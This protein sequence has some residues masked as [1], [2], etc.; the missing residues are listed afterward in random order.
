[1]THASS[2]GVN[3]EDLQTVQTS[4]DALEQEVQQ[5]KTALRE[6]EAWLAAQKEAFQA[7]LNGA[8]LE[9]P[10]QVLV[11]AALDQVDHGTRCA[12]Y[13][14]D[15]Q[16]AELHHVTGMPDAYSECVDG[17]K[18][19]ANSLACGLAVYTGQ[20]VITAD[21]TKEPLWSSWLW[22]AERYDYRGCWSFPI[23]TMTGKVVGT[24]AMYFRGPRA[25]TPRDYARAAIVT[26]TA[27]IIISHS[28]EAKERDEAVEALRA[29]EAALR[30]AVAE[31]EALLKELH[32]RVKNNL[33]VIT[34]LLEIQA[35]QS[36]HPQAVASLAEA[37]NRIGAIASMHELLYR[38]ESL[39]A[40]DL[41]GYARRLVMHVVS[42]YR[43]DR[44]V[45]VSVLGNDIEVDLARAVP[46]GLLLNE[47]V[48]NACKH[49]FPD[50][51]AGDLEITLSRLQQGIRVRVRDTGV[52]LPQGLAPR[53]VSGLGLQLVHMLAKQV[54]GDVTFQSSGGTTVDVYVPYGPVND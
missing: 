51:G 18:V 1:M 7:A 24:F 38:S 30:R 28:R 49:A 32:H 9:V 22:L 26:R 42:F 6:N 36:G 34:S 50:D 14:T 20:P 15:P 54:G 16:G 40:V 2:R 17:F 23:E 43:K 25:A 31:R 8:S 41:C 53:S 19:A 27:A 21:V 48:S 52:G 47:L 35:D 39:S 12:F 13:V 3:D 11:R 4:S 33:Q 29:S 44:R 10:L 5:E 46:L 37:R 45:A